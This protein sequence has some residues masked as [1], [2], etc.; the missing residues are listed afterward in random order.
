MRALLSINTVKE[1]IKT[2]KSIGLEKNYVL[3]RMSFDE[4]AELFDD[5]FF[6]FIYFDGYAHTGE[7]GG[8]TF[9]DWYQKLKIKPEEGLTVLWP[10][11]WNFMHKGCP[12]NKEIKYI[13]TGWYNF[14]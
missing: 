5:E 7:E 3:L 6:D 2:L 11:N 13:I 10:A 9:S 14:V 1:Y 4:A 8:K 12:A